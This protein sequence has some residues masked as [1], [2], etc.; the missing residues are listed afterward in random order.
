[1]LGGWGVTAEGAHVPVL[2]NTHKETAGERT[3]L[4]HK[5]RGRHTA[6]NLF[7]K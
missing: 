1:M 5:L 3:S 2:T 4:Q 6:L 7:T